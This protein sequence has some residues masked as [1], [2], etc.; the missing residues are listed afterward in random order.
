MALLI[1]GY[2]VD[3]APVVASTTEI[4]HLAD[5]NASGLALHEFMLWKVLGRQHPA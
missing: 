3:R 2:V 4:E 5:E 1:D